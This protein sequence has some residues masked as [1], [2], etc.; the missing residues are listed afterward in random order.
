MNSRM[1][2]DD[3]ALVFQRFIDR[4]IRRLRL[5]AA[6]ARHARRLLIVQIDGLPRSVFEAALHEGRMPF[7]RRLLEEGRFHSHPMAVGLPTSTPAFQMAAMYGVR[8]DIPGFHFHDKRRGVDVYFPRGGDAAEVE[9]AQAGDRLGILEGGSAYGCVFDGGAANN[10]FNFTTIKRPSGRGVL[11]AGSAFVILLWVLAK[12]LVLSSIEM[13]RAL[14]RLIADPVGETRRGW[15]WLVI[16]LAVSVWVRELFT[17]VAARD[18]Y[19]GVPAVY[20]NYLD[21]D[22]PCVRSAASIGRFTSYGTSFVG[23]RSTSTTST[24][25][26]TTGRFTRRHIRT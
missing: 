17:L 9:R 21:Y 12:C 20:V 10:L 22:G 14:L 1:P 23:C 4:M 13:A 5:G 19:A 3:L 7:V 25:S 15:R 18:L 2:L 11:R 16:K 26:A 24:C 6:P 8:P